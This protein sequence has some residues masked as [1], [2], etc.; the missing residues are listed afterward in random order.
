MHTATVS[1][2]RSISTVSQSDHCHNFQTSLLYRDKYTHSLPRVI[3]ATIHLYVTK[4]GEHGHAK[5]MY[6]IP[7]PSLLATFYMNTYLVAVKG[8]G[9][10]SYPPSRQ[11]ICSGGPSPNMHVGWNGVNMVRIR[12]T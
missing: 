9:A 10:T 2:A 4:V 5:N 11:W 8:H 6:S 1:I 3:H 7:I 12:A